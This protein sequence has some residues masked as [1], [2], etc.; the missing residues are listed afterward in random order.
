MHSPKSALQLTVDGLA[1][2]WQFE[3]IGTHW[4]IKVIMP[5]KNW[6]QLQHIL[7]DRIEQFDQVY[8]RFRDDSLVKSMSQYAGRYELPPD[9][10]KLLQLYTSMYYL[11]D[12]AVTPLIGQ[13]L[14]DAGYDANYRLTSQ[15]MHQ[16][17]FQRYLANNLV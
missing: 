16:P 10:A 13:T 11:T 14:A 7:A 2:S 5:A 1:H 3:A 8:S 12:G 9:A 4:H 15:P 6:P 17:P